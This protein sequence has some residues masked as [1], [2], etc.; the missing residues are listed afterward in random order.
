DS[1]RGCVA[2]RSVLECAASRGAFDDVA[3]ARVTEGPVARSATRCLDKRPD[4]QS[5][6]PRGCVAARSV[7]ECAASRGAFDDVA[8]VRVTEG[9]GTRAATRWLD[10]RPDP[11]SDSPPGGVAAGSVLDCAATRR[12]SDGVATVR[13][14][15]GPGARSAT[16]CLDKRPDPQSDSPPGVWPREAFWSAPRRRGAFDDVA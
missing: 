9:P 4:P 6:S 13:V 2:A 5:D 14:T 11:Q 16:R 3:T 12:A 1:P 8:T 7:L 10:K 15:E